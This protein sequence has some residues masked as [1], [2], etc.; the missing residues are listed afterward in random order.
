MPQMSFVKSLATTDVDYN[1]L[2]GWTYEY[3]PFA[4]HVRV[5]A[6]TVTPTAAGNVT[7]AIYSGSECIQDKSPVPAGASAAGVMPSE[8]N[9][10]PVDFQAPAGDRIR[11]VFNTVDATARSIQGTVYINPL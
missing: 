11:L 6:S 1:P 7:W 4:A 9:F 3:L 8:L 2:A 10:P 5:I